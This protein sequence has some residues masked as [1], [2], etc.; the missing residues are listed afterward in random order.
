[1]AYKKFKNT[2]LFTR[3]KELKS[4][5][6]ELNVAVFL[7]DVNYRIYDHNEKTLGLPGLSL[8]DN[9]N[10]KIC[11]E[12]LFNLK[13]PCEHC[14]LKNDTSL[15]EIYRKKIRVSLIIEKEIPGNPIPETTYF[16][17]KQY[18]IRSFSG[19]YLIVSVMDDVSWMKKKENEQKQN[20][21]LIS[22]GTVVHTVAHD[23]QNPL[24]GLRL[25]LQTMRNRELSSFP[26]GDFTEK[27]AL[28]EKDV[29]KLSKIVDEIKNVTG[30]KKF[31]LLP[32]RIKPVIESSLERIMRLTDSRINAVWE[33]L[34]PEDIFV[35]GNTTNLESIFMNLFK[36]SVEAFEDA[37]KVL[38]LNIW[39]EAR[40]KKL[41][42]AEKNRFH[43][44]NWL[45]LIII[46]NAGGIPPAIIHRVFDPFF[47]T[48]R[49]K[50][51]TGIG[52]FHIH[53]IIEDH[54]GSIDV[55]SKGDYT[56]FT[57]NFPIM[58]NTGETL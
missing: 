42:L 29:N 44:R 36:N 11:Y 47:T 39:V 58:E 32:V 52:L 8:K 37:G 25:T 40:I 45:E 24:L 28:L 2:R 50:S 38:F 6:N 23:M 19:E 51:G 56:R 16:Q 12:L 4:I 9:I 1:L 22:L 20:E 55:E 14:I 5:F 49:A 7:V 21:K 34:V 3:L 54:E 17:K 53:K 35:M 57:I 48:K 30:S 18:A 15:E 13:S 27:I 41:T 43:N 46:D 31:R 33:W 10:G 26:P